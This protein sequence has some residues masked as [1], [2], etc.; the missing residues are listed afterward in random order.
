MGPAF[1]DEDYDGN[2]DGVPDVRQYNVAS[3]PTGEYCQDSPP[4]KKCYV[5]I[6][7]PE[8]AV[9][10]NVSALDRTEMEAAAGQA[11]PSDRTYPYGF[12]SF[13]LWNLDGIGTPFSGNVTVDIFLE[14]P[15]GDWPTGPAVD[16]YMKYGPGADADGPLRWV[17]NDWYDFWY[18]ETSDAYPPDNPLR[19]VGAWC[20]GGADPDDSCRHLRMVLRDGELGDNNVLADGII[21]EPGGP[22]LLSSEGSEDDD[23]GGAAGCGCAMSDA[24]S[25][26]SIPT[27]LLLMAF[28]G[29]L[30]LWRAVRL[31]E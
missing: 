1:D 26:F 29:G 14:V 21:V 3:L 24:E 20:S 13:E 4:R 19:F 12:F 15:G 10:H 22:S 27:L 28:A 9:L 2:G 16:G 7:A 18:D 11:P 8:E 6:A 30:L 25:G 31:R 17:G 5:T 23:T